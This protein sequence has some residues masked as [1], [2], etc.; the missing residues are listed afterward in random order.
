MSREQPS[1][2]ECNFEIYSF[3]NRCSLKN[4]TLISLDYENKSLSVALFYVTLYEFSFFCLMSDFKIIIVCRIIKEVGYYMKT[5]MSSC[6]EFLNQ[7]IYSTVQN[8][9]HVS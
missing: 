6:V 5:T 9:F 4:Y 1:P 2:L 3:V 7:I 8:C